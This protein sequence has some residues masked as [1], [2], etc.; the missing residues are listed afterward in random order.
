MEAPTGGARF[1]LLTESLRL[2]T[3]LPLIRANYLDFIG[4]FEVDPAGA[5]QPV[6][7]PFTQPEDYS[8]TIHVREQMV[9]GYKTPEQLAGY[10]RQEELRGIQE[11]KARQWIGTQISHFSHDDYVDHA[12]ARA[13]LWR[14][15]MQLWEIMP[16]SKNRLTHGMKR[17]RRA[18]S[19]TFRS[20]IWGSEP[21]GPGI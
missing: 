20:R 14:N 18:I 9:E 6:C 5:L 13:V 17:A 19:S 16:G 10:R 21:T 1:Q 11:S 4:R 3:L 15:W 8:W 7:A 2:D 12:W